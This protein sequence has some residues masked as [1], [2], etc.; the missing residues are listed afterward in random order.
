MD[1]VQTDINGVDKLRQGVVPLMFKMV[2]S[3]EQFV[4]LDLPFNS[5]VRTNRVNEI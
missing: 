4:Q 2:E 1:S 5:E 3:L